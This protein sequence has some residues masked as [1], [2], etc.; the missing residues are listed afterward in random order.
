MNGPRCSNFPIKYELCAGLNRSEVCTGHESF[1]TPIITTYYLGITKCGCP[2]HLIYRFDSLTF[3][4]DLPKHIRNL[5]RNSVNPTCGEN[6]VQLP[7]INKI[8][9]LHHLVYVKN[10]K[11]Q[12]T[13][14]TVFSVALVLFQIILNIV[15]LETIRTNTE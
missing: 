15:H 7:C 12:M 4:V 6:V 1:L 3:L 9:I 5:P 8:Y 2:T 13:C 14:I 10:G 11:L